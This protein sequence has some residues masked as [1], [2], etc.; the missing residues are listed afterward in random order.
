MKGIP[1]V[2][3]AQAACCPLYIAHSAKDIECKSFVMGAAKIVM[4]FDVKSSFETQL[5]SYCC[6]NYKFCEHYLS[7]KHFQW[8]DD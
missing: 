3:T 5:Q 1:E 8:L 7:W 4:R 6:R 2:K